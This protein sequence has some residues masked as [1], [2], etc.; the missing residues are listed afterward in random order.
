MNYKEISA[1]EY[2]KLL[3]N[4]K[5][6]FNNTFK[7]TNKLVE[8][9]KQIL[10]TDPDAIIKKQQK[11][12]YIEKL[13]DLISQKINNADDLKK[14]SDKINFKK[15]TDRI[16]LKEIAD[17]IDLKNDETSQLSYKTDYIYYI[18]NPNILA[19]KIVEIYEANPNAKPYNPKNKKNNVKLQNVVNRIDKDQ[20]I[21]KQYKEFVNEFRNVHK[22]TYIEYDYQTYKNLVLDR[23]NKKDSNDGIIKEIGKNLLKM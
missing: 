1:D 2:E 15:I 19:N 21:D 3:Q 13:S 22:N 14:F 11:D 8:D 17:K 5:N 16:N 12:D 10:K 9:K 18:K 4:K 7:N 23:I 6:I 20:K